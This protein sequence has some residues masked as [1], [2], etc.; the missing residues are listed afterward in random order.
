MLTLEKSQT[1]AKGKIREEKGRIYKR[2]ALCFK[3]TIY[4]EFGN[5]S[6]INTEKESETVIDGKPYRPIRTDWKNHRNEEIVGNCS[7]CNTPQMLD[8]FKVLCPASYAA[9]FAGYDPH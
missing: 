4:T 7:G 2:R 9:Y 1:S 6:M 8:T 5:Y 3:S